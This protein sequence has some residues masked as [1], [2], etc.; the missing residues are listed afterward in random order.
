MLESTNFNKLK[1][2]LSGVDIINTIILL[3]KW[4]IRIR[5]SIRVRWGIRI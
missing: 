2:N 3:T 1:N 4:S 5:W